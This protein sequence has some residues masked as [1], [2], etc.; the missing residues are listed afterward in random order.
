MCSCGLR[1]PLPKSVC[2]LDRLTILRLDFNNLGGPLP[3]LK[4]PRRP[5][6]QRRGSNTSVNSLLTEGDPVELSLQTHHNHPH[7]PLGNSSSDLALQAL[8][9]ADAPPD[10]GFDLPDP[11][12]VHTRGGLRGLFQV[13]ELGL[14]H[15]HLEG[16]LTGA[17]LAL[18]RGICE[19]RLEH[20]SLEERRPKLKES[21]FGETLA[22]HLLRLVCAPRGPSLSG[23]RGTLT[24]LSA[25]HNDLGRSPKGTGERGWDSDD[26]SVSDGSDGEGGQVIMKGSF[27]FPRLLFINSECRR[28]WS[29][30][31]R[32]EQ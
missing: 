13:K 1:G 20:N 11:D 17:V 23:F 3:R 26:D 18:P 19:V 31:A 2:W 30:S 5:K 9:K 8:L 4:P 22:P 7:N 15:N 12:P 32:K 27:A 6:V 14:S 24:R 21:H 16:S 28:K 10:D 25:H 29:S